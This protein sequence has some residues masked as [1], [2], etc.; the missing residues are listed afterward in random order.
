MRAAVLG[1]PIEHSL[2]PV[3]HEAGYRALGL[4]DWSY[5]K[6]RLEAAELPGFVAG[7]ADDWRGLSLTMPLKEVC[8][9]VADSVSDLAGRAKAGNTLVRHGEGWRA[10]NTDVPGLVAALT[11]VW[12]D[13]PEISVLGAGATARSALL[14]AETLGVRV[15]RVHAR[16][17][18]QIAELLA[19]AQ[20]AQLALRIEPAQLAG[21]PQSAAPA[22]LSTLPAGVEVELPGAERGGLLFDAVY[23][24][25]PTPLATA[26]AEAG[27]TVVGGLDL[28]VY[29]AAAQFEQFTGQP[30]PVA[31]MFTAGLT[32]LGRAQTGSVVL[33]G[34]MG[35]GKTTTGRALAAALGRRFVDTDQVIEQRLGQS[36]PEIFE[37]RGEAGFRELEASVIAEHLAAAPVVL[38]VGGG[39]PMQSAVRDQLQDHHVVLLEVS[40]AEALRRVGGDPVRPMLRGDV[41][42]RYQTR[43]PVYRGVADQVVAVDGLSCEQVVEQILAGFEAGVDAAEAE[44]GE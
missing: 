5:T 35:A 12:Q 39:A 26:A 8:L 30:A 37:A 40:L 27:M 10:D 1:S 4:A 21:W 22:V 6:F 42:G 34:F 2:S 38:S 23:A 7:L 25:W 36:I 15:A 29:Q 14:A 33:V 11:G 41:A 18:T 24:D 13:W 32:A 31:A 28:L 19:W 20:S 43:R 44:P 9:A 16:R 17:S 3:L